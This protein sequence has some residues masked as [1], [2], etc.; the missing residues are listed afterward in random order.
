MFLLAWWMSGKSK[1]KVIDYAVLHNRK[2]HNE[3]KKWL[4]YSENVK[5]SFFL[6]EN[7]LADVCEICITAEFKKRM[8]QIHR[9]GVWMQ[10]PNQ[11]VNKL[12]ST[13]CLGRITVYFPCFQIHKQQLWATVM[14]PLSAY[15]ICS[16]A[17]KKVSPPFMSVLPLI[18]NIQFQFLICCKLTWTI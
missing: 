16:K 18:Q 12:M 17:E 3:I 15:F 9:L 13:G 6:L 10:L 7:T 5:V 4:V 11:Y 2:I 8:R 14:I 1:Y